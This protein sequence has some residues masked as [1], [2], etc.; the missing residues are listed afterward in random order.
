MTTLFSQVP[1]PFFTRTGPTPRSATHWRT[2]GSMEFRVLHIDD[3]PNW[4]EAGT[5]LRAALDAAGLPDQR[6]DFLLIRSP[7]DAS[8][9]GFAGSPTI[10]LDG[11]DL[12]PT[13]GSTN[14]LACRIY[15]TDAGFAGVPTVDQLVERITAHQV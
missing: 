12:I 13:P 8:G 10:T 1:T 7:A 11:V 14:D 5:R 6:F 3:C 9:T 2:M 4:Q 15:R